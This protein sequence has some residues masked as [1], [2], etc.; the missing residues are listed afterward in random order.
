MANLT[1]KKNDTTTDV[2]YTAVAASGGDNSPAVWRNNTVGSAP[3]HRPELRMQSRLNGTGTARRVDVH[4]SYPSLRTG[5]DGAI[6][7]GD[8]G[9]F[10]CSIVVPQ[11]MADVDLNEYVS[12]GLNLLATT[13]M[14]DSVKGGYAP[15]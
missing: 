8:R 2:V 7:I 6:T 11:G 10:D 1:V 15:V 12:Q 4:F 5:T 13:L 14:K 9:V 3:A